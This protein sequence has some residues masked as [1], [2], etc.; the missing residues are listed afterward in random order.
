[1]LIALLCCACSHKSESRQL[2]F[3]T[4]SLK[5]KY[6]PY[7]ERVIKAFE[8]ER[9]IE[10]DWI[11]LPQASILQ[12]LMASIAGGVPPDVVN[13]TTA[14]ALTLAH[15]GALADLS[16]SAQVY[17]DCY[18][19]NLWEAASYNGGVY[20]VPWYLSTRVLIYNRNLLQ[21]AGVSPE[22]LTD[23]AALAEVSRR[24]KGTGVCGWIPVVRI[25]DDWRMAGIA[26][27][28]ECGR[29]L[30]DTPEAASCLSRYANL[31]RDELV[32]KDF[33]IEGYQ[34]AIER[35][36]QNGLAVLE[37]GPQLLLK[38]K[39]DAPSVYEATGIAP[40]PLDKAGIVPA[41]MMN[42]VVP[43]SSKH[44]QLAMEFAFYMANAENQL[45]F[46]KEVPLL[47]SAC[48]ATQDDFF[49]I[50][51]GEALQDEAMRVSIAQLPLARD[52]ALSLPHA[53]DL[54]KVLKEA[55]ESCIYGKMTAQEAL[56]R[57]AAE[58]NGI[59]GLT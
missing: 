34:G 22:Y 42:L 27:H 8:Q 48:E 49:R 32:P 43:S 31:Y 16:S 28:D 17:K 58:W 9:G 23:K 35:Y 2:E 52:C 54:E 29:A 41:S 19:P 56:H 1:M 40:L 7:M 13:L 10:V 6:I 18:F 15:S 55:V 12:K 25:L 57:A 14:S 30:F 21:K 24:L 47:P 11:D 20:A 4:I 53:G 26:V 46:A 51:K 45:D 36:K 44:R 38:I 3:W 37:A 50:G 59:L 33:L 39:A 5:P